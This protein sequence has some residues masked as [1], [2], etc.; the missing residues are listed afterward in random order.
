MEAVARGIPPLPRTLLVV[1]HPDDETAGCSSRLN[2]FGELTILH[3]TDGAPADLVDARAYGFAHREE[4]AAARR[5]ELEAALA[6]CGMNPAAQTLLL[7][8]VDQSASSQLVSLA[9]T[10]A[11]QIRTFQPELVLTHP[12]EGGHPD[13]DACAL[14]VHAAVHL[15]G[16]GR[17]GEFASYH[18]G[19]NGVV[20]SDFLPG[21]EPVFVAELNPEERAR[22]E[23]MLDLFETQR[24]ILA[25]FSREV[26]RYRPAP[27]YDFCQP[28]H[29]GR[30]NYEN[31]DWKMTG[32]RFRD[33]A[34]KSLVQLGLTNPL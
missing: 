33:L 34:G 24:T 14:A 19:L 5:K 3:V 7:G 31:Y 12:Y 25:M 8:L 22:K 20:A 9:Q 21:P 18:A 1:A 6:Y 17:V 27:A 32:T 4:Y 29:P 13:H 30:L 2:R 26:E 11:E 16:L 28:P 10:I 15:A 23:C